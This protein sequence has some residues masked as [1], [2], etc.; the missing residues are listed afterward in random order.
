MSATFVNVA[1]IDAAAGSRLGRSLAR[2]TVAV[3]AVALFV[4]GMGATASAAPG[5][6]ST[7]VSV[8]VA[9]VLDLTI[10][11]QPFVLNSAAGAVVSLPAAVAYTVT[12]NNLAGYNVTVAAAADV[13]T[14]ASA[15]DG[16]DTIPVGAMTVT[17]AGSLAT[18]AQIVTGP[19][20]AAP[21][22]LHTQAVRSASTGDLFT[23]DYSITIPNVTADVYAVALDYVLTA[24]V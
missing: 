17:Q 12:S 18:G 8:T 11:S 13:L 14:G 10:T 1:V 21:V 22:E 4:A 2:T 16:T 5:G 19:T 9:S 7:S 15:T 3:S 24:G 6:D 20:L 23:N